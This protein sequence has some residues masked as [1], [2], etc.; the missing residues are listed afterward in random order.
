M[1]G[2]VGNKNIEI[3]EVQD[4]RIWIHSE[5]LG[6]GKW[7]YNSELQL[8]IG[9]KACYELPNALCV[10][11]N[12]HALKVGKRY[13]ILGDK[14]GSIKVTDEQG[15]NEWYFSECFELNFDDL[16][17]VSNEVKECHN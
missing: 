9:R 17:C 12:G 2:K 6:F 7:I 14:K 8:L 3:T 4:E 11:N 10:R 1:K 5:E 15:D 13:T 16:I